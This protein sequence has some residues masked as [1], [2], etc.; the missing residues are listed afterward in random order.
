[1]DLI[2][3]P[4]ALGAGHAPRERLVFDRLLRKYLLYLAWLAPPDKTKTLLLIEHPDAIKTV[5]SDPLLRME[6]AASPSIPATLALRAAHALAVSLQFRKK[7]VSTGFDA[8]YSD[9]RLAENDAPEPMN[10]KISEDS[11]LPALAASF[12]LRQWVTAH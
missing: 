6:T 3:P 2:H 12:Y 9:L 7:N 5:L 11:Q 10:S 4:L 8:D 1:M